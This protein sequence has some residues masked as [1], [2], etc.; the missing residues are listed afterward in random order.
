MRERSFHRIYAMLRQIC[1]VYQIPRI[2][3]YV[4]DGRIA[5]ISSPR[6]HTLPIWA[7]FSRHMYFYS[8]SSSASL[9]Q[10]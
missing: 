2:E 7:G 4:D 5:D 10:N 1:D 3:R 6:S 8:R 9:Q